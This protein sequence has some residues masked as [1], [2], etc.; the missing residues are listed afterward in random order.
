MF[1]LSSNSS[2]LEFWSVNHTSMYKNSE[3]KV[4]KNIKLLGEISNNW[5]KD[6]L[7]KMYTR[8]L[9][10]VDNYYWQC[11]NGLILLQ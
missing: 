5:S 7:G 6:L 11:Y 4:F 10:F 8:L 3:S 1:I 9:N 2:G